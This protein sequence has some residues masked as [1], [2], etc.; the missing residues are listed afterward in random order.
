MPGR[1]GLDSFAHVSTA[2]VAGTHTGR[3]TEDD[4]YVGQD[5]RNPY[6][7][8]KFEAE[9]VVRE[10]GDSLPTQVVRPSIVVG[11]SRTG[12]TPAFNVLYWPLR[13]FA[14]APTRCS[15]HG[16]RRRSTSCRW[17]TSRT[18]CSHSQAGRTTYHLTAGERASSVGE[19]IDLASDVPRRPAP[20]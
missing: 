1:G 13:A 5:F 20:P 4:L 3:F 14:A 6:E 18:R 19:L 17:T 16:A 9:L 7:R 10:R 15:R 12:W 11:D 8:S 2:Y